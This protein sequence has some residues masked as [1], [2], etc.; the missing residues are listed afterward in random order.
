MVIFGYKNSRAA[1]GT[2]EQWGYLGTF[3][4]IGV[5]SSCE[6]TEQLYEHKKLCGYMGSYGSIGECMRILKQLWEYLGRYGGTR[7]STGRP[8]HV[9]AFFCS[10]GKTW[11][12]VQISE[13]P[14]K[15]IASFRNTKASLCI[16][17]QL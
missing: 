11:A 15:Y 14:C 1:M 2:L 12:V 8:G 5:H 3:C 9:W 13:H 17:R 10:F 4:N 16:L 7:A 6:N